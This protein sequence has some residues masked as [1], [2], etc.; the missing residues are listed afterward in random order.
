MK[1]RRRIY[2]SAV[3]R[4]EIWD[5]WRRGESLNEIG[6]LFDRGHSSISGIIERAHGVR[7]AVR[8]RSKLALTLAEREEISRGLVARRSIRSIR[9]IA[10][11]LNRSAST[12]SREI[13]RNCGARGYRAAA[14]DKR[15]DAGLAA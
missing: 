11:A 15:L 12:V 10:A 3:Q 5:R 14:A 13:R 2:Y 6:R 4:A 7:P 9:S 8:K 1:Q